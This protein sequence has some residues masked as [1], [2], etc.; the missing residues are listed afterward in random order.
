M[1]V[2]GFLTD[3]LAFAAL[4]CF[5]YGD[6]ALVCVEIEETG[7]AVMSLAVPSVDAQILREEFDSPDSV[8]IENLKK[9]VR[10][11]N[12]IGKTLRNMRRGGQTTW[13]PTYYAPR[14]RERDQQRRERNQARHVS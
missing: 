9:Y 6:D 10:S 11:F 13:T 5:W 14:H 4:L 1:S 2:D 3:D 12:Y 8:G 7:K